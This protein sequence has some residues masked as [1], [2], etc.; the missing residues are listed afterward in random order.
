MSLWP[1]RRTSTVS[2]DD[3]HNDESFPCLRSIGSVCITDKERPICENCFARFLK[4]DPGG[5]TFRQLRVIRDLYAANVQL[6]RDG[7]AR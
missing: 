6:V 1:E 7:L 3:K 5:F 2:I 4:R